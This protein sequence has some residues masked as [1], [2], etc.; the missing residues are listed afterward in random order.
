MAVPQFPLQ[1]LHEAIAA[2]ALNGTP[3]IK[4]FH[5]KHLKIKI[6]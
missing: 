3:C 6:F 1:Q 5:H 2:A 4:G